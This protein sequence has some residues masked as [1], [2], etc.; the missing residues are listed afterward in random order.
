ME[1][2]SP[3]DSGGRVHCLPIAEAAERPPTLDVESRGGSPDDPV[4]KLRRPERTQTNVAEQE[5]LPSAGVDAGCKN[6]PVNGEVSLDILLYGR[7]SSPGL[8]ED[9]EDQESDVR[10]I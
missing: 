3:L 7:R 8:R 2:W 1:G 5:A 10:F 4:A 6:E 9:L